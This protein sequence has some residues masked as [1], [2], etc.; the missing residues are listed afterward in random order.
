MT[1]LST[2]ALDF[3]RFLS[4]GGSRSKF[5]AGD[6]HMGTRCGRTRSSGE[7][8]SPSPAQG[9]RTNGYAG[10]GGGRRLLSASRQ[11]PHLP[12]LTLK[13]PQD[14]GGRQSAIRSREPS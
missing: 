11:P 12:V 2:A 8:P 10:E 4:G 13:L 14:I 1:L 9:V 7:G 3:G 5:R 6:G